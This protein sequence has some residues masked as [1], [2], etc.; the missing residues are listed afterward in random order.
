MVKMLFAV[1]TCC[2][3][4]VDYVVVVAPEGRDEYDVKYACFGRI[5]AIA[6][7]K[8][9]TCDGCGDPAFDIDFV[10]ITEENDYAEI[11]I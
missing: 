11:A 7:V 2:G 10:G 5:L 1:V 3:D 8:Q 6:G 4:H 9:Y